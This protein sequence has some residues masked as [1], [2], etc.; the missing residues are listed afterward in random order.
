MAAPARRSSA[1]RERSLLPQVALLTRRNAKLMRRDRRNM[2]LLLGQIPIL[3]LLD[4]FLFKSGIFD[5][6]GGS[7]ADAIQLLYLLVI[8]AIWLGSIDAAREIVKENSVFRR[9]SAIGVRLSAYLASKAVVLFTLVAVQV[10]GLVGIVMLLRPLDAPAS[11]YLGVLALLTVVGFVGVTMGLAISSGVTTEDQAMSFNPLA[12]IP[13]L[14]FAGAIVPVIQMSAPVE[15]LSR[16]MFAQW[17]LAAAGTSLDMNA[18]M[19]EDPQHIAAER[20]GFDFFDV[21]MLTGMLV[22]LG[23]LVLFVAITARLLRG[24]LKH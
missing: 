18:R 21:S 14:L 22:L 13:Q 24:R 8:V 1:R 15:L 9:E 19:A 2:L 20:Y 3:A 10:I 6:S 23:F 12:L 5:R 11:T 4:V 17:A 16:V 7:P